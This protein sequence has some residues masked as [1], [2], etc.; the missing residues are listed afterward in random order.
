MRSGGHR[1]ECNSEM[2][3]E[4][5]KVENHSSRGPYIMTSFSTQDTASC[6]G[7]S[8]DDVRTVYSQFWPTITQNTTAIDAMVTL[9]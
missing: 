4:Q 9:V 5:K 2:G 1:S 8:L 3:H 6:L 7:Q